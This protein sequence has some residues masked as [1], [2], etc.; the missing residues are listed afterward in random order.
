LD[1]DWCDWASLR[2]R[3]GCDRCYQPD[4]SSGLKA[5][6][7]DGALWAGRS[8]G[9]SEMIRMYQAVQFLDM[10]RDAQQM[11]K[12]TQQKAVEA[13]LPRCAEQI[14]VAISEL[15]KAIGLLH[16]YELRERDA[17]DPP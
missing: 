2:L 4:G 15:H 8:I 10:A 14:E 7:P 3:L 11:M 6:D 1:D 9:G 17:P 13:G 16:H 5:T 12:T